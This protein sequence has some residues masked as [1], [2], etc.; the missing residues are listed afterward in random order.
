MQLI[1]LPV[2][3]LVSIIKSEYIFCV[4][5]DINVYFN[6]VVTKLWIPVG[7]FSGMISNNTSTDNISFD[8]PL[9]T[10]ITQSNE[11]TRG[12]S[13]GWKRLGNYTKKEDVQ[14]CESWENVTIDTVIGNEEPSKAY[15]QRIH[16]NYHATMQRAK[17]RPIGKKQVKEKMKSGEGWWTVQRGPSKPHF[18]ERK[19]EE[20]EMGEESK[21]IQER[22]V[23]M[24][25]HKM[26]A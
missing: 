6:L 20:R 14:L 7:D 16:A 17:K 18:G 1:C 12:S 11:A 4:I 8:A 10:F 26:E 13:K 25:E 19:I 15:W 24:E 21:T 5:F 3:V 23:L 9:K 2:W 22:K